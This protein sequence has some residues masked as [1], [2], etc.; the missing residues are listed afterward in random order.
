MSSL[1]ALKRKS[2]QKHKSKQNKETISGSWPCISEKKSCL[3]IRSKSES[4]ISSTKPSKKDLNLKLHAKSERNLQTLY[5]NFTTS[6]PQ[7]T[8]MSTASSP[9]SNIMQNSSAFSVINDSDQIKIP[10]IGYEVM[11]ERSRFTV[12]APWIVPATHH[13]FI[14]FRYSSC[15]LKTTNRA[16]SGLSYDASQTSHVSTLN[17]RDSIRT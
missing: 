12:S 17:S 2:L 16:I 1:R 9:L 11:E 3:L 5:S 14:P 13:D 15:E 7:C 10:I 8:Y 4:D 6:T